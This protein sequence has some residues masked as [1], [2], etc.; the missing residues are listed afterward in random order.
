LERNYFYHR[1]EFDLFNYVR[2]LLVNSQK[3]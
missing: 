2:Y 3:T 1:T